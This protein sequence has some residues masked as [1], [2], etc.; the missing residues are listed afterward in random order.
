MGIVNVTP[1]SFSDGGKFFDS[2]LAIEH[3]LDV[4][5]EGAD[6]LD[7]GGESTRPG[8][9]DPVSADE[10]KRRV[11]PVIRGV[12]RRAPHAI[13]SID[14]YK[15][16]TAKAALAEGAEIVN[17][18]SGFTWDRAMLP[19][20]ASK[21]CACVLMHTRGRP[22]EWQGLSALAPDAVVP[23]V[24]GD[25]RRLS[26]R[27]VNAGVAPSR[28][29]LDPGFGFGKRMSE[30]F[31][32]LARLRELHQLGFPLLSG[33][34]RKS[35]VSK[36]AVKGPQSDKF[37]LAGSLASLTVAVLEGVHL[38]RVHDVAASAEA[39][40]VA[41][42]ILKAQLSGKESNHVVTP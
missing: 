1:D 27:A 2:D 17:D 5:E 9:K 21:E 38:I 37:G 3:G 20:L 14:T 15:A 23:L 4:I 35:F 42:S 19:L 24:I 18:V 41:D 6:I 10:E 22:E 33:S 39:V 31:P 28:I 26:E 11:L 25:L 30:N 36:L 7:I 29:V 34:S 32:L 16:E 13:V 12:L 8:K 40:A